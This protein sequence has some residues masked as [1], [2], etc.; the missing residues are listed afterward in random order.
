[1]EPFSIK[2]VIYH[3]SDKIIDFPISN[4]E[5][6]ITE[7]IEYSEKYCKNRKK[8][9]GGKQKKENNIQKLQDYNLLDFDPSQHP[10]L[11]R[12]CIKE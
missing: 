12:T 2:L 1:M 4:K 3:S 6:W 11:W 7:K 5:T 9:G 10:E 8:H